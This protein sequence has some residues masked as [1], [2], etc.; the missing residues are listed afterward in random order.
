MPFSV[1]QDFDLRSH[2]AGGSLCLHKW[3]QTYGQAEDRA[4]VVGPAH[5]SCPVDPIGGLEQPARVGVN[6][7][8]ARAL[9]ADVM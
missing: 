6:A 3:T 7:V 9:R 1:P 8:R 5:P 4:V 2:L